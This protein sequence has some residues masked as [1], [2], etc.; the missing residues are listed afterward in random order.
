MA[1]DGEF[2]EI[3][4]NTGE[5]RPVM[6]K[7]R[8]LQATQRFVREV[9][10]ALDLSDEAAPA[11]ADWVLN[12]MERYGA[13]A[14]QGVF[15]L[16]GAGPMCSWCGAIWPLCGHNHMSGVQTEDETPGGED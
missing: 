3:I 11:A 13:R 14:A 4:L 2:D 1:Y 15:D 8:P 12:K 5:T 16:D 9:R 6:S 10:D 7:P